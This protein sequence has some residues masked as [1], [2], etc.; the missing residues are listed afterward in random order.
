[1][2]SYPEGKDGQIL[3]E[4]ITEAGGMADFTAAATAYATWGEPMIPFFIFY[5]M[6]GF[7]RVGDLIW[8][9][10]DMPRPRLPA[11]R[12]RRAH[13]AARRGPPARRRP[14]AG[15]GVDGAQ[16]AAYDPAFAYETAAIVARRHPAHVRPRAGGHLLLPHPLQRELRHAGH[17]GDP[18]VDEGILRGLYRFAEA[19]DGPGPAGRPS[20]SP[21]PP[22]QAALEAQQLLAERP[23]RRRRAVVGD[24]LQG[25]AGGRPERRALEPPPPRACSRRTPVCHRGPVERRGARSSPSPTS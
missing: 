25:A 22:R 23:R 12:H 10:G 7:Q 19:P 20:C 11:R 24:Q 3:E 16:P 4:G 2:L 8:A 13:H 21:G 15:A 6:F 17:A 9:F 14:L 1:M 18:G 5:S